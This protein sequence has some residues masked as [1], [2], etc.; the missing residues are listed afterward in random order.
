MRNEVPNPREVRSACIARVATKQW[1][2]VT[3]DQ[4]ARCGVSSSTISR[5]V[6]DGRLHRRH[7]GVYAVGHLSPAP[8]ARWSA[9]LLAYGD[10]AV[11]TRHASVALHGLGRPPQVVTVGLPR[12]ARKQRGIEPHLSMPF[13]PG[14]VVI[15]HGLRTTSIERTLLDLVAEATARRLTSIAKLTTYVE[16]RAGARG[17]RRLRG[18]LEGSQTRSGIEREFVRWL[19]ER[20][21][22]VPLLNE[23]F[24]PYT[25]DGIWPEAALILE[26]DSF[27]THGTAHSFETDRRRD[28]YTAARGLRTIRVTPHRWRH[29]GDR[30]TRDV[31]RALGH[32]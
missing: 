27:D 21:I 22:P 16:R 8:E 11:M 31:I 19:K 30:L 24:G 3:S 29:D 20:D 9:A 23:P 15:R 5:W 32:R 26:I 10:D 7:R 4:L 13:Q 18:C 14:E 1:G 6:D 2:N 17:A 12:K 28:A 25:L